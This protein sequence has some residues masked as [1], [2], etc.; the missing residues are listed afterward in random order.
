MGR[1]IR[2]WT[3]LL[4]LALTI[5]EARAATLYVAPNGNDQWSGHLE[6]PNGAGTDGPLASLAGARDAIRRAKRQGP[7]G[8]IRVVIADGRY[9]LAEALVFKPEDSG[10]AGK[11]IRYE[12]APGA[13][14][15]FSGGRVIR[16]FTAGADGLWT[17]RLP[18]VA[19]G[20]WYFEQLYVNGRRAVRARSPNEF[21]YYMRRRIDSGIDPATGQVAPLGHRAFIGNAEDLQGLGQVPRGQWKDLTLVA[22]HSW[23]TSLHRVADLDLKAGRVILSGNA[24]WQLLW[25]GHGQ[26]YHVENFKAALD[27]PGEWF[28]D[29]DGTLFYK[30]LPGEEPERSEAVAPVVGGGLLRLDG[31]PEKQRFVEHLAF[32][33]LAFL[34]DGYLLPPGGHA[35]GQASVTAPTTMLANGARNVSFEA[36]QIGHV[37]GYG[38]WFHRGCRDCRLVRCQIHDLGAGGVRIGQGWDSAKSDPSLVTERIT[39]DNNIIRNG[40]LFFRGA[41][42]VWVGHASHNQVTHNEIADF[43]YTGVSVGWQWGYAESRSHHNTIDFNHIHHI[44]WGV[45]SDMGGVYTLGRSPGTTVSHNVIHDVYSYDHYGRGGWG[46][47]NDEGSSEIVMEDNLVYRVKTGTYHQHYGRENVIRNNILAYSLD[48]QLQRSRVEQ[49]LSFTFTNNLVYWNGGR[50]FH[51]SWGDAN[52]KLASNLY[53]DAS[54]QPVSFEGHTLGA[55]QASGKDAGSMV[56]DPRFVDPLQGDFR[57]RPDSPASKVG[58]KPFDYS[59]AGVYGDAQW[60]EMARSVAYPQV[61]FAP[62]PPPPPPLSIADDFE[63]PRAEPVPG[64][65]LFVENK[66]D[67]LAVSQETAASGKHSLKVRD[68]AGLQHAFN[69]HFFYVPFHHEGTSICRFD[70]QVEPDSVLFTEWRDDSSPYRVGPSLWVQNGK[71]T[72][73]G[74]SLLDLPSKVWVRFEITAN[75][76][77]AS[78]G[79]WRLRVSVPGQTPREFTLPVAHPQWRKLDWLG[80]CSTANHATSFY[81]DNIEIENQTQTKTP[82]R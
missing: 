72:A 34:H 48:G 28:L 78:T 8:A 69:P 40:G 9:P 10:T 63:S 15:V 55:W 80:F 13:S 33:G 53:Y 24:P 81:L 17:T 46:L 60:M 47:Y 64:A 79:Q 71:L 3:G 16:G 68:A 45:L 43:R 4:V 2:A 61:R 6:R 41:V 25:W 21:Y 14:P 35:D 54:G 1:R 39:V 27:A 5:S 66:G 59:K 26:R 42:G 20:K 62:E 52:V 75:L 51:G 50:L 73:G 38:A 77:K 65:R 31:E 7:I 30:P 37:G 74:K 11:P 18:E 23:E 58:F 22:Y 44:G 57:L 70:L 12:A 67:A 32:A 19:Q 36:C 82:P 56:A 76:G 29:R 49:H